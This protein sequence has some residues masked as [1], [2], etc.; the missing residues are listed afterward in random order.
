MTLSTTGIAGTPLYLAPELL[1]GGAATVRSDIYSVGVLLYHLLTGAYPVQARGLRDLRL[2]H[3][4]HE[5]TGVRSARPRSATEVDSRHRARDQPPAGAAPRKMP[6]RSAAALAALKP[7]SSVV[8]L[9]YTTGVAAVLILAVIVGWEVLGPPGGSVENTKRAARG[10][11][12]CESSWRR[13]RCR[14]KDTSYASRQANRAFDEPAWRRSASCSLTGRNP[15]RLRVE[16]RGRLACACQ[17]D[18]RRCD[19]TAHFAGRGGVP[20][21]VARRSVHRVYSPVPGRSEEPQRTPCS[22][23]PSSEAR[24]ARSG[25]ARVTPSLA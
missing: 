2:A 25:W 21:V 8:R 6:T 11:C 12:R 3:E 7:R 23:F 19:A 5:R 22:S 4:R 1:A 20:R 18:R 13:K 10:I 9:A 16:P 14:A 15:N 17:A 24:S